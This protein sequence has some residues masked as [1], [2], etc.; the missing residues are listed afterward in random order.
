MITTLAVATPEEPAI[1]VRAGTGRQGR[2]EG[3]WH[4]AVMVPGHPGARRTTAGL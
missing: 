2:L 4:R 3:G 1:G